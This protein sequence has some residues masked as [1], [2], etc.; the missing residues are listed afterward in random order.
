[1]SVMSVLSC[2]MSAALCLDNNN[3]CSHYFEVYNGLLFLKKTVFRPCKVA[4][5]GTGCRLLGFK[6]TPSQTFYLD[7]IRNGR[8]SSLR[9]QL[10]REEHRNARVLCHISGSDSLKNS[11]LSK[12]IFFGVIA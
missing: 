11:R 2:K 4:S 9:Y 12:G 1:M 10:S 7:E 3:I 8:G 6:R 5:I